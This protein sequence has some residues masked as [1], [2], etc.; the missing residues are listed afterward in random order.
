MTTRV[1]YFKRLILDTIVKVNTCRCIIMVIIKYFQI[2]HPLVLAAIMSKRYKIS[3]T[4]FIATLHKFR[5]SYYFITPQNFK[6]AS[7]NRILY[8]HFLLLSPC[9]SRLSIIIN[10]HITRR[11]LQSAH[12]SK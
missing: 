12:W 6:S 3:I 1:M 4:R 7:K 5:T 9:P 2:K 8:V 11:S 10:L